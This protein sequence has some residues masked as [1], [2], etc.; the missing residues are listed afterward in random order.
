LPRGRAS[1]RI[2]GLARAFLA[3]RSAGWIAVAIVI[4]VFTTL[5][6][7]T[8]Q[9]ASRSQGNDFSSY[10]LSAEALRDGR[11]PYA[12]RTV[13][14]YVYPLFLALALI[15][16]TALPSPAA[17]VVWFAISV[18][19]LYAAVRLLGRLAGPAWNDAPWSGWTRAP[20]AL[21]LLFLLDPIQINL[22]NGQVNFQVLALSV[23]FLFFLR[24]RRVLLAAACLGAAVALKLVPVLLALSLLVRRSWKAFGLMAAC[25]AT[26]CLA[27]YVVAG[28]RLWSYYEGYAR[29]FVLSHLGAA[30]HEPGI[31][32]TPHGFIAWL[33]PS[34]GARGW[35]KAVSVLSVLAAV[36]FC[37]R[38]E[39]GVPGA[40]LGIRSF[41]LYL[42]AML[43]LSPKSEVH[44]LALLFP[45]AGILSLGAVRGRLGRVDGALL[46]VFWILFWIA[47]L[48]RVGPWY[49][50]SLVALF[51]AVALCDLD[52][53]P[54][55]EPAFT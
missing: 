41:C 39:G 17:D 35:V 43:L 1:K 55:A 46:A 37:E 7:Q 40:T 8:V 51:A 19:S 47:R 21:L 3:R 31:F 18:A 24:G 45:A 5:L 42:L 38:R 16:L 52:R 20:L 9:K 10:R 34:I 32:F 14:P 22:L 26:F 25:A 27:P 33:A 54:A 12:T 15:P 2:A 4:A 50:L 23:A 36:L 53:T 6:L 29:T 30:A 48:D 13:F 44:H 49:F 11:D 28:G